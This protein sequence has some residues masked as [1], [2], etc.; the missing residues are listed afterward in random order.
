MY[1]HIYIYRE[2]E[3]DPKAHAA[4]SA[5][6]GGRRGCRTGGPGNSTLY[7]SICYRI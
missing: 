1:V 6:S 3:G 2:R 4:A 7:Y 5:V